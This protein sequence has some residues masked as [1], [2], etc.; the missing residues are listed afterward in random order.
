[1]EF[2]W[3]LVSALGVVF[4]GTLQ[5]I[6]VAVLLSLLA[7][8]FHASRRPVFVLGRK[9]GTDIF[10]PRCKEHPE[11]ESFA[12]LLLIKTEGMIH[13]AN[14]RR[15][16]DLIWPLL[17]EH[18]PQVLVLDCSAIPDFEYTAIKMLTEAEKKLQQS[19]VALWLAGLNPEP[20]RLIQKSG[21]GQKLGRARMFFNLEQAVKSYLAQM[22]G[23]SGDFLPKAA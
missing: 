15:I 22:K 10:R 16:G 2:S 23:P 19:G 21:L 5:G 6:L 4:L 12:G 11:D 9:P 8:I 18:K 14:A 20:L 1:M 3:A 17:A 13:F 7:L